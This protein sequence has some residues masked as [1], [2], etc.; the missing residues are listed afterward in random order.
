MCSNL[1]KVVHRLQNLL[2]AKKASHPAGVNFINILSTNISYEHR[3]GSFFYVQVTYRNIICTKNL[4]VKCWWNWLLAC[5]CLLMKS[6]HGDVFLCKEYL[7]YSF[8][9]NL[10][11]LSHTH[12]TDTTHTVSPKLMEH[13]LWLKLATLKDL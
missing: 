7:V 13:F 11:S 8:T 2:Y 12:S 10:A 9:H 5:A 4:R 1:P 3:F 6:T